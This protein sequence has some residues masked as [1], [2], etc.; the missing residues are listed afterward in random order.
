MN[1]F[2]VA[3]TTILIWDDASHLDFTLFPTVTNKPGR[4]CGSPYMPAFL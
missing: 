2:I 3:I 1:F 4:F